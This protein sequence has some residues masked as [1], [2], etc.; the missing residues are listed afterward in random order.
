MVS[1]RLSQVQRGLKR[2]LNTSSADAYTQEGDVSKIASHL[3]KTKRV[4]SFVWSI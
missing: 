1:T 4:I 3:P 2:L